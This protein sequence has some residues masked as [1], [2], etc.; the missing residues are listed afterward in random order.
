MADHERAD[1]LPG[2]D[3][4]VIDQELL[5]LADRVKS[6]HLVMLLEV[7]DRGQAFPDGKLPGENASAQLAARED[8]RIVEGELMD[9]C[10]R[11]G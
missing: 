2:L 11:R 5:G 7:G 10:P 4:A 9:R 1:S 8:L 3:Q 6:G